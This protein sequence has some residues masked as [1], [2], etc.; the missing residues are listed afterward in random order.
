MFD[1][2]SL[3]RLGFGTDS[4]HPAASPGSSTASV[5]LASTSSQV[6]QFHADANAQ[7]HDQF[8]SQAS[9]R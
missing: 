5:E 6:V 8:I 1:G 7:T 3:T 2:T 4:F 9:R